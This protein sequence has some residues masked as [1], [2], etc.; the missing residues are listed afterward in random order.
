MK[1]IKLTSI[2]NNICVL[3]I[4]VTYKIILFLFVVYVKYIKNYYSYLKGKYK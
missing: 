4:R 3:I 2:I 1:Y